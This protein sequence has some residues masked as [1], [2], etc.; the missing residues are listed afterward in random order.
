M[1]RFWLSWELSPTEGR[2]IAALKELLP[3][4]VAE[5]GEQHIAAIY[6]GG[7]FARREMVEGSD[8]DVYLIVRENEVLE[9]AISVG[10]KLARIA[11]IHIQTH[12]Y[13]LDELG[14]HRHAIENV[15]NRRM[16]PGVLL[17][18]LKHYYLVYGGAIDLSQ[19][20]MMT[21]ED[22]LQKFI[23]VLRRRLADDWGE[24]EDERLRFIAKQMFFLIHHER[25][26]QGVEKSFSRTELLKHV[27]EE[28]LLHLCDAVR[29]D[30]RKYSLEKEE[31]QRQVSAYLDQVE[32][33]QTQSR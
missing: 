10:L 8:L 23:P 33:Q 6:V 1:H 13:S 2:Y 32:A 31:F 29:K 7:S 4:L 20:N 16:P 19:Y 21:D 17:R 27:P 26:M 14:H 30:P 3:Q 12:V 5:I 24:K 18:E 22:Y 15:T 25:R 11:D 28:H 9:H